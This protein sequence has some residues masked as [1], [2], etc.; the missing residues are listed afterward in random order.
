MRPAARGT[1]VA[2]REWLLSTQSSRLS[3]PGIGQKQ[4]VSSVGQGVVRTN[5][6]ELTAPDQKLGGQVVARGYG[7]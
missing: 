3:R 7:E 4:P 1:F 2:G 5:A 6:T